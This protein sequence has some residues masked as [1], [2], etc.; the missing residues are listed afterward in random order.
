MEGDGGRKRRGESRVELGGVEGEGERGGAWVSEE[1]KG[2]FGL[3]RWG[4]GGKEGG[5]GRGGV[6]CIGGRSG[7]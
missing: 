4:K 1:K 7:G 5:E 6:M 3:R 2:K